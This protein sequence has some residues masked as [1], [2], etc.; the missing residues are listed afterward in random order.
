MTAATEQLRAIACDVIERRPDWTLGGVL[1]ALAAVRDRGRVDEIRQAAL[2]AAN[3]PT[4]RTPSAIEFPANWVAR[5]TTGMSGHQTDPL[6]EC[7]NCGQ[8]ASRATSERLRTCP[9]C[10]APWL[11]M[12]H[13]EDREA[14]R[15]RAVTP[16]DEFRS[17][18]VGIFGTK[19]KPGG[20]PVTLGQVLAPA[21]RALN[22]Y[23][24]W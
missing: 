24:D 11:P 18:M 4:S 13:H 23:G 21:T 15:R 7:T 10:A 3:D 17:V 14:A 8:P 9:T 19:A 2:R 16:N 6:P 5:P 22:E 1:S 12:T 20:D